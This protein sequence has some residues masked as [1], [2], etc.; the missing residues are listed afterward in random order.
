M[1]NVQIVKT[2]E[3]EE[4]LKAKEAKRR[5]GKPHAQGFP[6][7][8]NRLAF[9]EL[10]E[11]RFAMSPQL[12]DFTFSARDPVADAMVLLLGL[13]AAQRKT[14]QSRV[15][16]TYTNSVA[17]KDAGR[18]VRA[19]RGGRYR[20][21]QGFRHSPHHM[22]SHEVRGLQLTLTRASHRPPYRTIIYRCKCG[23]EPN[24]AGQPDDVDKKVSKAR[25]RIHGWFFKRPG[26]CLVK[27]R[28]AHD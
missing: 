25:C 11:T 23:R 19:D 27:P 26:W 22:A 16:I 2:P 15:T 20:R 1:S 7:W 9:T 8:G 4:R 21:Y 12:L 13:A 6:E 28:T 14:P 17:G 5:L 3:E 10:Q 24:Q 18:C